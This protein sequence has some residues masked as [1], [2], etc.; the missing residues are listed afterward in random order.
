ML[1]PLCVACLLFLA[2]SACARPPAADPELLRLGEQVVRLSDFDRHLEGIEARS[3]TVDAT[4]RLALLE[5]FLEERVLVLEA[6]ERELVASGASAELERAA[7]Q[8]LLA[9]DVLGGLTVGDDEIAAYYDAHA[10][11]LRLP[12]S[13][14]LSQI[15]V[16]T[17]NEAR[18]VKRRLARDPR[19]FERLVRTRSR[20]PEA[21]A[22]GRMGSFRRGELPAELEGPA[23]SLS[24]G[25]TSAV[26]HSPFGYHVLKLEARQPARERALEECRGE[27]RE[28][29]LREKSEQAIKRYVEALLARAKVNYEAAR[30]P[31]RQ[32]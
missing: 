10:E 2:G 12:E 13:I 11:Q 21:A 14:T 16:P 25:A 17:E 22:G 31:R 30:S 27:I 7:V 6:R 32:S 15:L 3:G 5:S 8:K 23:F 28:E 4:V 20:G 24:V 9:A 1:R 18:D 26:L 29:L 19:S